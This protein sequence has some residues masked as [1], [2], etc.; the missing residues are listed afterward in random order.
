MRLLGELRVP[1]VRAACRQEGLTLDV[2]PFVVRIRTRLPELHRWLPYLYADFP[3]G[4]PATF[5]D[6]PIRLDRPWGVRRWWRPQVVFR[7][8]VMAPFYPLARAHALPL[9][10][11]GLNWCVARHAHQY[12]LLHAGVL[13][14]RGRV[15][16]LPGPPGS[17]KSTLCAALMARGWRLFSDELALIKPETGQ[18]HP[19][20]R[21]VS[22]KGDAIRVIRSYAPEVRLGPL[23]TDTA[24]GTV[25][26]VRPATAA[27]RR[28]LEPAPLGWVVRP[29]FGAGKGAQLEPVPP[30]EGFG[31]LVDNAF[32]YGI[33]GAQAFHTL[34]D[35]SNTRP[36]Y[37]L[38]YD[39]LEAACQRLEGLTAPKES[40]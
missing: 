31:C 14:R 1:E 27:V 25:A 15:L 28:A 36:L 29:A 8:D 23:C 37:F 26:H 39:E 30:E 22:L 7:L 6:F 12:L 16:V 9:L 4:A 32:N 33:L 5:A 40:A 2:G 21:P 13:E 20:P 38:A 17:G 10:E 18:I 34:V 11:W 3:V 24:K 35:L 19:L